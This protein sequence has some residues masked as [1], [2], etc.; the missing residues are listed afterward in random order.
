M[1]FSIHLKVEMSD[2]FLVSKDLT[3]KYSYFFCV[4]RI[5]FGEGLFFLTP[6]RTKQWTRSTRKPDWP[7]LTLQVLDRS[8]NIQVG[9]RVLISDYF[10][11]QVDVRSASGHIYP[12]SE[13][14]LKKKIKKNKKNKKTLLFVGQILSAKQKMENEKASGLWFYLQMWGEKWTRR[15]KRKLGAPCSGSGLLVLK[16]TEPVRK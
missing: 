14:D 4:Q 7:S 13:P 1:I 15:G 6:V 16:E 5:L 11:I 2:I 9:F 3:V 10:Q 12:A 8:E